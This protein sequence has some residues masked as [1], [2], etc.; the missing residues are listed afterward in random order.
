MKSQ[1][2][3]AGNLVKTKQTVLCIQ[4][5]FHGLFF[6]NIFFIY[7]IIAVKLDESTKKE[8]ETLKRLS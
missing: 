8:A 1:H 7:K 3:F 5:V 4:K 6:K 2:S